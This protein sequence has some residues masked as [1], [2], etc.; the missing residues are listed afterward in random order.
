MT[1]GR[2]SG[3]DKSRPEARKDMPI[4]SEEVPSRPSRGRQRL[5]RHADRHRG[6]PSTIRSSCLS[7]AAEDIKEAALHG[8][9]Q[10]LSDGAGVTLRPLRAAGGERHPEAMARG[11]PAATGRTSSA[12]G[13][14]GARWISSCS[15][16]TIGNGSSRPRRS[17]WTDASPP[18]RELAAPEP[19]VFHV[20]Q[21]VRDLS[22]RPI[23]TRP[24][25][26]KLSR[27]MRVLEYGCSRRPITTATGSSFPIWSA[28][29]SWPTFR[30]F[31]STTPRYRYRSDAGVELVTIGAERFREPPRRGA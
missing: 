22:L 6:E 4:S 25:W 9:H 31:P 16:T 12:D 23:R 11:V 17:N 2:P 14:S 27:G 5:R 21:G 24:L 28:G 18:S 30:T 10:V 20:P 26:K 15:F 13:R 29:G 1:T 8:T 3:A 7:E 19:S